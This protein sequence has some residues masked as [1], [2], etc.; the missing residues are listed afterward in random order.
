MSTITP[1]YRTIRQLLQSQTFAIDE[2]QRE[3]KWESKNIIEL[4]S[5]LLAKFSSEY[6]D[7][8][9]TSAVSDYEDYFLGSIIVS[10]RNGK[11]YLVDGQQRVTSLTLLLI[12]LK[13]TCDALKL[14][15][16]KQIEP[17]IFSDNFGEKSFNLDIKERLPVLD[18]LYHGKPFN[19]DGQDESLR[20]MYQRFQD[21]QNY[22]LAEELGESL[23]HFV[24]W[25]L[26]KVGLI[27]IATDNDNYAY[28]IFETMNDRGKPL[29][30][31]DMLKAHLLA[32]IADPADRADA[33]KTWKKEVLNLITWGDEADQER[34]AAFIKSWF[35]AKY[36]QTIRERKKGSKDKD[37]EL[38]GSAFHRWARDNPQLIGLTTPATHIE[39]IK[40][41]FPFYARAY[42]MI[43][44]ASRTFEPDLASVFYNA[45]NDFTWQYTVL[46]APLDPDDDLAT[47]RKKIGVTADFL[48]IWLMRRVTNYVRVSYSSVAYA[49]YLLCKDIRGKSLEQLSA[50]LT[51]RLQNDDVTFAGAKNKN[52]Q[53]LSD[54]RLNQFSRRYILHML[55]RL[56]AFTEEQSGQKNR[57]DEYIDRDTKNAYDIEHIWHDRFEDF[58]DM[59]NDKDSFYRSRDHIASLVLLPADVNRSL[60]DKSYADKVGHYAKQNLLAASLHDSRYQNQPQFRYFIEKYDLPFKAYGEYDLSAQAERRE[61]IEALVNLVWSPERLSKY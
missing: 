25:L 3:Y 32:K 49:M 26:N 2:Y 34:D 11:H 7:G 31:V 42:Q 1:N 41:T 33:N 15:P 59:F 45:N 54:F 46:L 18:A 58:A 16:G 51:E 12:Y 30:P 10:N 8:D 23:P 43:L 56:T 48:D 22:G 21:I 39:L 61:L 9:A 37:W 19:T 55:A 20:T 57:F 53:G 50:I 13:H 35:R 5:D 52:R 36:A 24:Y 27:E 60:Q 29:S 40:R 38:I 44:S 28:A 47:T 14:E 6:N 17:L 4:L